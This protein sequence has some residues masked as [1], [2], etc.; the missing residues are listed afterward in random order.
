MQR[1]GIVISCAMEQWRSGTIT[2]GKLMRR[3]NG[4]VWNE[5]WTPSPSALVGNDTRQAKRKG[6]VRTPI[7]QRS[8][9][10][11]ESV[12]ILPHTFLRCGAGLAVIDERS[13]GCW[14]G[15]W[16]KIDHFTVNEQ[17][18]FRF[19]REN[20]RLDIFPLMTCDQVAI[21]DERQVRESAHSG[22]SG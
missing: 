17:D 9:G 5:A 18:A 15:N 14:V 12:P 1:N 20:N 7:V 22:N 8:M 21:S 3:R 13:H 19:T 10:G 6:S 16:A 2:D 11:L 4:I